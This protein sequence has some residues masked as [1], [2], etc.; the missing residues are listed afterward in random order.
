MARKV[1]WPPKRKPHKS[2]GLERIRVKGRDYYLGA[3]GSPEADAEYARL[4]VLLAPAVSAGL[5]PPPAHSPPASQLS[6][7]D[8]VAAW[9]REE[10]SRYDLA[11]REPQ[12]FRYSLK[13]LLAMFG[14][15]PAARFGANELE[16]V[17]LAMARGD[18]PGCK[19]G[20]L[21]RNVCNRRIVR[22][23]TVWRWADRKGL[24]PG[25][26]WG[27]LRSLPELSRADGRARQTPRPAAATADQVE[28]VAIRCRT[29]VGA[30]VRLQ[31]LTGMRSGELRTMQAGDVDLAGDVWIYRPGRHKGLW[32][33]QDR[34]VA[35]GP[36]AQKVL[37]PWLN[38]KR[39]VDYVFPPAVRRPGGRTH[40]S[41]TGYGNA[42]RRAA[43][44]AGLPPEW[45]AY[46]TRH[47]AKNRLTRQIGLDGARAV[48]GQRSLGTTAGYGDAL[49]LDAAVDAARRFG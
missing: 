11:S 33:G 38:G 42:V 30:M 41:D 37:E 48:L 5:P 8:V 49:D 43:Q 14:Q 23:R 13:P 32:R 6:V 44:K 9:W 26:A 35:I 16:Q 20:S 18:W 39:L 45:R 2:S 10:S 3:P 1:T 7:A 34:S 22:I 27:N 4:L 46:S 28:A 31:W 40:Y 47:G 12:Q 25:G 15:S 17:Q 19:D 29:V 36:E 24:V 21:C